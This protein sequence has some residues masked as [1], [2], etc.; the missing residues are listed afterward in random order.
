MLC[1][2]VVAVKIYYGYVMI[3]LLLAHSLSARLSAGLDYD[4]A[5]HAAQQGDWEQAQKLL[6]SLLIDSYDRADLLYDLGIVSYQ[7]GDLQKACTYFSHAAACDGISDE[8]CEQA[9]FNAGNTLVVLD[10]LEDAI[11]QYEKV[12]SINPVNKFARHNLDK[13]KEML[14]QKQEQQEKQKQKEENQQ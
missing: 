11:A 6:S 1:V 5:S 9:H 7:N 8:L 4:F 3:F 14:K 2:G 12:L 13:V 10:E